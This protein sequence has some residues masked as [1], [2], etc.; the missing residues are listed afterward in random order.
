MVAGISDELDGKVY[1]ADL[2]PQFFAHPVHALGRLQRC[3]WITQTS[4]RAGECVVKF[5]EGGVEVSTLIS[6]L[7]AVKPKSQQRS[8]LT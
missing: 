6:S 7:W 8:V 4:L 3:N 1:C 5:V 2:L